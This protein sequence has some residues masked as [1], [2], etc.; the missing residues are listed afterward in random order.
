MGCSMHLGRHKRDWCSLT[1][2]YLLGYRS[3]FSLF[4]LGQTTFYISRACNFIRSCARIKKSGFFYGLIYPYYRKEIFQL[5]RMNQIVSVRSWMGG[6][7]TNM[8]T[9][10]KHIGNYKKIPAYVVAFSLD[11]DNYSIIRET[12]RL[13][14]PLVSPVDSNSDPRNLMYPIPSNSSNYS[15]KEVYAHIFKRSIY[16]GL[17]DAI[18]GFKKK[19]RKSISRFRS[20]YGRR[21]N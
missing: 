18:R 9:F 15:S 2:P 14:L 12:S 16:F 3:K 6:F 4:D 20:N 5:V 7:I 17:V 10:K 13:K 8:K 21:W 19:K 1:E 11:K